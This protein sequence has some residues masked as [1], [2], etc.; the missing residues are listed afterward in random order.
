M[1]RRWLY[2]GIAVAAG[3]GLTTLIRRGAPKIVPGQTRLLLIGD[4]LA[5]GLGP[6]IAALA[7]EQRV[8]F[9]ADAEVGTR[10][11]QWATRPDLD[12]HLAAF[13]PTLVLVS[14]GT[15]DE[16]MQGSWVVGAQQA[17][18]QALLGKLQATGATVVWIGPPTLPKPKSNGIVPMLKAA[19][20]SAYYF[21]SDTALTL[22]RGPDGIHPTVAGYAG[23]A[24]A[25]WQWLS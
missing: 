17:K 23:W 25:L 16:Y 5:V 13:K 24:G 20:P 1:E 11:D 6:P 10:I 21:P 2:A 14:L 4:S 18:L 7:R 8:A 15:N 3:V 19:I 9:D 22:P 12:Q